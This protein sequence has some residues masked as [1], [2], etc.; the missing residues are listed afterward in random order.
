ME[1]LEK[2]VNKIAGKIKMLDEK[3]RPKILEIVSKTTLNEYEELTRVFNDKGKWTM[4]FSDRMEEFKTNW[5]N[6]KKQ[7]KEKK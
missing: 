4:E 3:V 1:K 5:E 7:P 2:I 6:R